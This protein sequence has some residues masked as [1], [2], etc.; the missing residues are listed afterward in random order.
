MVIT[1][2]LLIVHTVMLLRESLPIQS[3]TF[4]LNSDWHRFEQTHMCNKKLLYT[5]YHIFLF[6]QCSE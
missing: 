4:L 3:Y 2:M 6:L 1:Q 5:I